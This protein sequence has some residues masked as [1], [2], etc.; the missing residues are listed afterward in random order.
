MNVWH[1]ISRLIITLIWLVIAAAIMYAIHY[2]ATTSRLQSEFFSKYA[3]KLT[4]ALEEGENP[5]LAF[6][7]EG[8]Y[9]VRFGYT[10]MPKM[11][12]A[13][14]TQGFSIV[15]QPRLS[16]S[17]QEFLNI[18]GYMIYPEKTSAGL[19]IMDNGTKTLH[20]QRFPTRTFESFEQIPPLVAQTLLFIENRELLDPQT[21]YRN[22]AVEWDRFALA[23]LGQL[24]KHINPG[25]NLGGGG[26]VFVNRY[27]S[28]RLDVTHNIV[29]PTGGG[30]TN[31]SN[32]MTVNVALALNFG[33]ND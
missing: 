16:S 23:G 22:P 19:T 27:V 31:F 15:H 11:L 30:T 26:R 14:Q 21:P 8:P 5:D 33:G 12:E 6:P 20:A 3:A 1:S 9:D 29:I 4:Y 32:V 7:T 24:V 13:L 25:I 10:R 17:L 2:E 18:G 28:F